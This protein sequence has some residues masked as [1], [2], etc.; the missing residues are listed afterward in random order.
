MGFKPRTSSGTFG[1]TILG[2]TLE[3]LGVQ[4]YKRRPVA[5]AEL[6]ANA[7]DAGAETVAIRLP[8]PR[9]KEADHEIVIEDDG[10]GMPHN[11]IEGQFLVVGRDRREAGQDAPKDRKPMGRKGIGKLAGF[12]IAQVVEV[13]TWAGGSAT[14]FSMDAEKLKVAPGKSVRVRIPWKAATVPKGTSATGTRITLKQLKHKTALDENDLRDA[15]A[16]RFSRVVR[17]EM[18]VTVNGTIVGEPKIDFESRVPKR[19]DH[20]ETAKIAWGKKQ[21]TVRYWYG[22]ARKPI[23]NTDLRG[24]TIYVRGKTAQAP[25]F[26]FNIEGHAS[27]QHGTRY[28]TGAIEADFLDDLDKDLISTDR[29]EIEW[30]APELRGFQA[31]GEKLCRKLL[32]QWADRKGDKAEKH[33][34]ENKELKERID[35]LDGASQKQLRRFIRAVGQTDPDAERLLTLAD[36]LVQAY[37]FQQFHNVVDELH[38]LEDDPDALVAALGHL[39]NWQVLES[40]AILEILRGRLAVVDLFE[41]MVRNDAP[42]TA[43]KKGADN[44]HDL[45]ASYPWLLNPD[46]QVLS[47]EKSIT[48]QLREWDE[49]ET[50][51]PVDRTRYDFLALTSESVMVVVEIKRASHAVEL[52]EVQRLARYADNLSKSRSVEM[53]M[54]LVYGGALNMS[55]R[56]ANTWRDREDMDLMTWGDVISRIR[57][58]Y[59]HYESVLKRNISDP[60]FARKLD[61]VA[62]TRKVLQNGKA[63]VYRG[64]EGR[65]KGLGPQDAKHAAPD[66]KKR[67]PKKKG[68]R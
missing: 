13:L 7:W 45:L 68:G 59:D 36:A 25:P 22:F 35:R 1:L 32:I 3:H 11:D 65:K 60:A 19:V 6:V 48:D 34:A 26:F 49:E 44:L 12:G 4:M 56:E 57:R 24:F 39:R 40:R 37:E 38:A 14:S 10:S 33:V 53:R 16:R 23:R 62:R 15:L 47:E 41:N 51:E 64:K 20:H 28:V 63:S 46:W 61:E 9:T 27:G 58:H 54:M 50:G 67:K 31:W 55:T 29:Q 21:Q 17:G 43:P 8:E 5:I 18:S 52:D 42:E 66:T 30:E 2:R